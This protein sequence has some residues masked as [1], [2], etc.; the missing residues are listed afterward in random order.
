MKTFYA[1]WMDGVVLLIFA[2][3][4]AAAPLSLTKRS[5]D[6]YLV[7]TSPD[8]EYMYPLGTD[9]EYSVAGRIGASRIAV[10]DGKA[11]FVDSPCPN[12]TCVQSAPL[13]TNGAW[14]AC[15]PNDIFIRIEGGGSETDAVAY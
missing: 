6:A 9:A 8:G 15:L 7:I 10:K 2:G 3:V 14:A 4:L 11:F 5:G 12:K 13:S 1:K